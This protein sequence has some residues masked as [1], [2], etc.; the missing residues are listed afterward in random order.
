M[1]AGK[2]YALLSFFSP[3]CISFYL[4]LHTI[5]RIDLK[6]GSIFCYD[7][8]YCNN[9]L[10][11]LFVVFKCMC[12][13]NSWKWNCWSRNICIY[14]FVKYCRSPTLGISLVYIATSSKR[15]FLLLF[16]LAESTCFQMIRF[17]CSRWKMICQSRCD[18]YFS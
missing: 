13:I 9:H 17:L 14:N 8:Q 1:E 4:C 2:L 7:K 12:W 18:L 16:S 6:V 10:H 5:S 11:T 3:T 15:M